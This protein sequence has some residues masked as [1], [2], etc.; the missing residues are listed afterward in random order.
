MIRNEHEYRVSRAYRQRLLETRASQ[1]SHPH[2]D[3]TQREWLVGGVD[4]LLGD[5]EAE[6]AEYEALRAGAVGEV[7]VAGLGDLPAALVKA[8]IAAGL[9]QRQ[10]A[11]RLGVA[12][13]AVQ[14]D[15]AGGYARATLDRLQRVAAAL[16]LEV[17][18]I[19]RLRPREDATRVGD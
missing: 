8:R 17:E 13:Q 19:L 15:E 18:G 4:R 9:T 6:I 16:G 11:E 14:R 7:A 12:E 10:L 3:P 2:A 1:V 5:V